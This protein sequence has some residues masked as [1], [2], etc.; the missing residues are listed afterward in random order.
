MRRV[1]LPHLLALSAALAAAPF[2]LAQAAVPRWSAPEELAR[3]AILGGVGI[4]GAGSLTAVW[5]LDA[6]GR[7]T[8]IATRASGRRSFGPAQPLG[9]AGS[10]WPSVE[11]AHSGEAL[12]QW[13]E[14]PS[15]C[16]S[17]SC[18]FSVHAR[19]R[20]AGGE[21]GP[22]ARVADD[23][24]GDVAALAESGHAIVAWQTG[25]M[26]GEIKVASRAP[27][28]SFGKPEVLA[29]STSQDQGGSAPA[30]AVGSDGSAVVAW[31]QQPSQ[32]GGT[33]ILA[34]YR[35]PAGQFGE[36]EVVH[37]SVDSADGFEPA[38]TVASDGSAAVAWYTDEPE[39]QT[40]VSL[41]SRAGSFGQPR[42]L[43]PGGTPAFSTDA[44]G[45][46]LLSWNSQRTTSPPLRFETYVSPRRPGG[47]FG[48]GERVELE[49]SEGALVE[50]DG[51]GNVLAAWT[52]PADGQRLM[53]TTLTRFGP[54]EP[55]QRVTPFSTQLTDLSVNRS[56][57]AAALYS[58][59]PPGYRPEQGQARVGVVTRPAD[60]SAPVPSL[61]GAVDWSLGISARVRCDEVCRLGRSA[62]VVRR[63]TAVRRA[64]R[65]P[66]AG[67]VLP[68]RRTRRVRLRLTRPD[69]A[70]IGRVLRR[71]GRARISL[72]LMVEDA[73]GNRRSVRR[74]LLVRRR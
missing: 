45:A 46:Q 61:Q 15:G 12:A 55:P 35:P 22:A 43:G 39:R 67:R 49:G 19:L 56:G 42:A 63:G 31:Q 11:V 32:W 51:L 24:A 60:E 2:G 41:R 48:K 69:R 50:L 1:R 64:R 20:S 47:A 36:P 18:L 6:P 72:K 5:E 73:A 71:R 26:V 27:G 40:F 4:D 14:R 65:A 16:T 10:L 62:T 52:P 68:A 7:G 33:S 23:S 3:G 53:V 21:L 28:G 13:R 57:S 66:R 30:V 44:S 29:G 25:P 74:R 59:Y 8:R 17:P 37:Q 70:R 58:L 34:A 9:P 38:A 54:Q